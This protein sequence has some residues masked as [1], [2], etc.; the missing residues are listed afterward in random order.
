MKYHLVQ[1]IVAAALF[2]LFLSGTGV[3]AE[4]RQMTTQELS[5]LRGT[6]YNASQQERDAFR[7][8]WTER[9][10]QMTPEE[11]QRYLVPGGGTGKGNRSGNGIGDGT[12]RG[13]GGGSG[14]NGAG[15]GQGDGRK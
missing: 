8:A 5:D 9:I 15:K 2:L 12:G 11:K 6:M 7:A 13:R 4:Y 1:S 3:G 10:K 14:M